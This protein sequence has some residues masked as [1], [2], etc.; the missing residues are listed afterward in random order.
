MALA[1]IEKQFGKGSIMRLGEDVAKLQVDTIP[2]GILTLDLALGVGGGVPRGGRV[3]EI[4][5]A[6]S[7]GKTTIA[8]HIIAEAQKKVVELPLL[9]MR[10][11]P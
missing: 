6:E 5:G 7:S 1:T 8:L 2:T 9:L 4:Y 11:M 10:N 3:I